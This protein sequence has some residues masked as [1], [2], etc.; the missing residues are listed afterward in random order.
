MG[1][2]RVFEMILNLFLC[3]PKYVVRLNNIMVT[4]RE[5]VTTATEIQQKT[6]EGFYGFGRVVGVIL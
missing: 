2:Q 3:P 5:T 6:V 4:T 1:K